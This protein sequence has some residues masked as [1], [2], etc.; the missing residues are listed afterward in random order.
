ME[1]S[2]AR[3]HVSDT[4][5]RRRLNNDLKHLRETLG[6]NIHYSRSK[7]SYRL[8]GVGI[9]L[10][11]LPG[12]GVQGLA[13]LLSTFQEGTPMGKQVHVLAESVLRLLPRE[14]LDDIGRE[15]RI[16]AVDLQPRD[17]DEIP[18]A[19]WD[20]VQQACLDRRLLEFDYRSPANADGLAR[21]HVVEPQRIHFSDHHYYLR[22][23][24]RYVTGPDGHQ[25]R[26][27]YLTYRLGRIVQAWLLPDKFVP[28]EPAPRYDLVYELM[29]HIARLG[30][31]QHFPNAEV[32]I[33][34]DGSAQVSAAVEDLFLPL[35][36]LLHYGPGCRVIAGEEAVT[37]MRG[38]VR[39]MYEHYNRP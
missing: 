28:R 17:T 39:A 12:D 10:L 13:F 23:F 37:R 9:P 2:R 16:I 32:V 22:A 11:D 31:T 27:E 26:G 20:A 19:V 14:R 6:C 8:D 30:V 7:K 18:A 35:R 1:I 36:I 5:A 33:R 21:R 24:C 38:L 25:E 15:R 29:P 3:D 4:A 34:P